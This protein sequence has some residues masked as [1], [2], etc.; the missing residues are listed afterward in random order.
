MEKAT[1]YFT[2]DLSAKGLMKAYNALGVQLKGKVAVKISTGE[3]GGHN[4][5]QPALIQDL[6]KA[7]NG[8]I[9]E[10]NTAYE[11]GALLRRSIGRPSRNTG[12]RPSRPVTSW[13][14]R[15]TWRSP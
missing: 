8:T 14:K 5:L 10:C 6:V 9:V 4:F 7:L 12:S 2:K 3:P 11:D 13:T 1:V 15:A